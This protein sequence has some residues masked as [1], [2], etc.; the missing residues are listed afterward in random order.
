METLKRPSEEYEKKIRSLFR[1]EK[2]VVRSDNTENKK[3]FLHTERDPYSK[4][5]LDARMTHVRIN[6][7]SDF[8]DLR[9]YWSLTLSL[10]IGFMLFSQFVITILLGCGL[11]DLEKYNT[12]LI[13]VVSENFL[14]VVG[15]GY[16]VVRFLF[17]GNISKN[18]ETIDQKK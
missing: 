7:A 18:K 3:D 2:E 12:F 14:Q 13:I 6:G 16:I 8:Y 5:D 9:K 11:I 1:I 15:M 4:R 17:N 10:F